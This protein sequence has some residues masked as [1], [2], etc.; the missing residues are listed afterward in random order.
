MPLSYNFRPKA[1]ESTEIPVSNFSGVHVILGVVRTAR[2]IFRISRGV[3]I[4]GL[5]VR[6]LLVV[7]GGFLNLLIVLY[8]AHLLTFRASAMAGGLTPQRH[9][10][11]MPERSSLVD[12]VPGVFELP[13]IARNGVLGAAIAEL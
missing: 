12:S 4:G 8:T 1:L 5:P 13:E 2:K 7:V 3:R 11:K 10:P 6:A 9:A